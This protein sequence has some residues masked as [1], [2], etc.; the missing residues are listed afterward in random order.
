VGSGVGYKL[1][2]SESDIK[3]KE[4]QAVISQQN[5]QIHRKSLDFFVAHFMN[6]ALDNTNKT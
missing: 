6:K 3:Q 5:A 1:P 2:Y 4:Q